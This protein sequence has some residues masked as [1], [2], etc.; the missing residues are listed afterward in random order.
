MY[1]ITDVMQI[2]LGTYLDNDYVPTYPTASPAEK[3]PFLYIWKEK[4]GAEFYTFQ[5]RL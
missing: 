1:M 2:R 5:N 3:N 4:E